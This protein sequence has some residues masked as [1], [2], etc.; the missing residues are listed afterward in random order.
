MQ[1]EQKIYDTTLSKIDLSITNNSSL[2]VS[3]GRSYKIEKFTDNKWGKYPIATYWDLDSIALNPGANIVQNVTLI[4]NKNDKFTP[5]LYR[6][7]KDFS[8]NTDLRSSFPISV[9]FEVK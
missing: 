1:L 2:V 4:Y 5:G 8:S 7:I 3:F 6:I 9:E